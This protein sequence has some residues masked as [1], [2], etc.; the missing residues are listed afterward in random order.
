MTA[1]TTPSTTSSP[2]RRGLR[3]L[4]AGVL[5]GVLMA[6]VACAAPPPASGVAELMDKPAERALLG[7]LRLYDDAQYP[8]AEKALNES[9]RLKLA[10]QRDRAMAHKT[11]A[12]IYC[13]TERSAECEAAFRSA[14]LADPQFALSKAEAGHPVWGPVYART[15][16]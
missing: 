4:L 1:C 15:R 16:R 11:L 8:E 3:W 14:R 10:S 6:L 2:A 12:F 7:G 9:L 5:A 13:T